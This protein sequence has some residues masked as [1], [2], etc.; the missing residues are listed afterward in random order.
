MG[1]PIEPGPAKGNQTIG[2]TAV[3]DTGPLGSDVC[4]AGGGQR[5]DLAH[6]IDGSLG[7][8]RALRLPRRAFPLSLGTG[9]D[10]SEIPDRRRNG[11][12]DD[13]NGSGLVATL[14]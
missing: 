7:Q 12:G 14:P 11:R 1:S 8:A 13:Y 10:A 2:N 3:R 9:R 6:P 5:A 4:R